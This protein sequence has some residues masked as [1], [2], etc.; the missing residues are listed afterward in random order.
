MCAQVAVLLAGSIATF[1]YMMGTEIVHSI[2]HA[3]RIHMAKAISRLRRKSMVA[4]PVADTV[5]HL[6]GFGGGA[7]VMN[8]DARA[9]RRRSVFSLSYVDVV[10]GDG[11]GGAGGGD[12]GS[13]GG[14]T[15]DSEPSGKAVWSLAAPPTSPLTT[16]WNVNPMSAPKF[17]RQ[18]STRSVVRGRLAAPV[19]DSAPPPP[20]PRPGPGPQRDNRQIRVRK[21][22]SRLP[23]PPPDDPTP[24]V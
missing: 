3:R 17:E 21:M 7:D 18:A 20:P 19:S 8:S 16:R 13:G 4:E 23:L 2:R 1:L 5:K 9:P 11:G 24:T 10:G 6:E 15:E 22:G 12:G 14:G